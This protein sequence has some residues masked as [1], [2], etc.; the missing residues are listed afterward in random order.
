MADPRSLGVPAC[1][2]LH[3][4]LK[5]TYVCVDMSVF[6][7]RYLLNT[8][9]QLVYESTSSTTTPP[10]TTTTTT[11]TRRTTTTTPRPT[12]STTTRSWTTTMRKRPPSPEIEWWGSEGLKRGGAAGEEGEEEE[13][14]A[15]SI[16][17]GGEWLEGVSGRRV[18]G[19]PPLVKRVD[20]ED[21]A[22]DRIPDIVTG[23]VMTYSFMQVLYR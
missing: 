5:T 23:V 8:D 2:D 17:R 3:V 9:Q 4:Y 16:Y 20:S 11:T 1:L 14:Q 19:G 22:A 13:H 10:I 18:G 12:T 15:D 21:S 7:P 6:L